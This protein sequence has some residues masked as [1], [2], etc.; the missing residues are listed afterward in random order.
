MAGPV[1]GLW[2]F[3][4]GR[5]AQDAVAG[6]LPWLESF[7]DPVRRGEDGDVDF[8]ITDTR[9]LG[10]PQ[11]DVGETGCFTLC[12]DD[13]V[14]ADDEDW[15]AFPCAPAHGLL[16]IAGCPGRADH[17][18]LGRLALGAARRLDALID[19]DGMLFEGPSRFPGTLAE[20]SYG[21][22]DGERAVRHVGD[23]EFLAAWLRHP[24]FR[25]VH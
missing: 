16:L 6:V 5:R 23:A 17:L 3:D 22:S 20:V 2:L 25:L 12:V 18:A 19:F 8:W 11:A 14:P 24:G 4:E 15:S 10:P 9:P 1:V 13:D 21:T 7:C